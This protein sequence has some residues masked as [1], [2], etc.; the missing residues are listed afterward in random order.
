VTN[1]SYMFYYFEEEKNDN[2]FNSG[3]FKIT[4]DHK[5]KD[6]SFMFSSNENFNQDISAWDVSNVTD[7]GYMFNSTLNFNQDISG[8]DVSNVTNMNGMFGGSNFNQDIGSWDVSNVTDMGYMFFYSK[9]FN[10][11][12][13]NW[14]IY[15]CR[16]CRNFRKHA[17]QYDMPI[18]NFV[19]C[20][21]D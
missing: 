1:M 19:F 8:W 11:D 5:V 10:Q 17:E 14:N 6:M 16:Y 7:M 21:P 9:K 18:P 4:K 2:Y 15:N 3:I 12:L 20:D 13:S